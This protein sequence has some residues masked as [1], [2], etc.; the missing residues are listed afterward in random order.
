MQVD[1]CGLFKLPSLSGSQYLISFV[2]DFSH[3]IWVYFFTR[4]DQALD[5][6]KIFQRGKKHASQKKIIIL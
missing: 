3:Q 4:K 5:K 6:F 2:D 1:I